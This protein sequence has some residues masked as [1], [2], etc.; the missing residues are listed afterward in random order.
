VAQL[1]QRRDDARNYILHG[2]PAIQLR[3]AKKDMPVLSG[4]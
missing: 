4:V 2:D 3:V 1:L